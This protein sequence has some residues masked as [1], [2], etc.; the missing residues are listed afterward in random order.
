MKKNIILLLAIG[1]LF[2]LGLFSQCNQQLV[3][4]AA[5]KAGTD[6]IYIRDFKVKLTSGT[7]ENPSPVGKFPVYL[8]EGVTYRFTLENASDYP[9]FAVL[10]LSRKDKTLGST[11][12]FDH[13]KDL[14]KFD[15]FCPQSAT[16]QV[17]I[18]FSQGQPGCVAAVM[19]MVLK[20]SM[21][22]IEPGIPVASDSAGRLYL[23][24]KNH[25]NI[26][27]TGIPGGHL[28]VTTD[29]GS[30]HH[31]GGEYIAEPDHPGTATIMVNAF[32]RTGELNETDSVKYEVVLPSLPQILLPSSIGN[33]VHLRDFPGRN[34]VQLNFSNEPDSDPYKL[35]E[36]TIADS[37]S[38]ADQFIAYGLY[39]TPQ[40][41]NFIRSKKAG[42]SF[43]I[44]NARF[45][46]PKGKVHRASPV[47]Y[48]V[49]E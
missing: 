49:A 12:D 46:D 31:E 6:A 39:L 1:L 47:I 43:Y 45:T 23:F 11:Y 26:A 21:K 37:P 22:V 18:S 30:V 24:L 28:E 15:F 4:Q 41:I 27:A 44:I 14:E 48:Y 20:D 34:T 36:F 29:N 16:Y 35:I 25:L 17:L 38:D 7:I 5:K 19:S 33:T 9:G 2:H 42:D 10:Q 8:N 40:Q 13:K 3:E 32:K